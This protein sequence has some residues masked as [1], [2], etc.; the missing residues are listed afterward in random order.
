MAFDDEF[1][2]TI[3]LIDTKE[4][5]L[6]EIIVWLKAKGLWEDCKKDLSVKII[7]TK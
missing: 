5:I 4:R 3:E 6:S 7:P 2:K 1:I